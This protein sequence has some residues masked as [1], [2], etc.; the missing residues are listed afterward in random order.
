M[1]HAVTAAILAT[2]AML[3]G[4]SAA[5]AQ[6]AEPMTI[7]FIEDPNLGVEGVD[8]YI[9]TTLCASIDF[10]ETLV[11]EIG[12]ADA[13][14]G[15]DEQWRVVELRTRIDSNEF[16]IGEIPLLQLGT[17][18]TI[19]NYAPFPT[20]DGPLPPYWILV[21]GNPASYDSIG[22]ISAYV[23]GVLCGT[24]S[25]T[26]FDG[27]P[28]I[29]IGDE[30]TLDVC[31]EY[32]RA[33]TLVD[34]DGQVLLVSPTVGVGPFYTLEDLAPYPPGSGPAAPS[35]AAAGHGVEGARGALDV[36]VAALALAVLALG[37][38]RWL[39]RVRPPSSR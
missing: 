2:L 15:C 3:L 23:G 39:A 12:G 9:G 10:D 34:G 38:R 31:R 14:A 4:A 25:L 7:E 17:T 24:G 37:A 29:P 27:Q 35:P 6:T 18:L 33:I 1:K 13:P 22:S 21:A 5:G 16:M 36:P 11:M 28:M 19:Q 30:G 26:Q 20:V 8:A 32:G